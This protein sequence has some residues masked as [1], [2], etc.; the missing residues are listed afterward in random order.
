MSLFPLSTFQQGVTENTNEIFQALDDPF[1]G[2]CFVKIILIWNLIHS[3][4][5]RKNNKSPSSTW[6]NEESDA[7]VVFEDSV[8]PEDICNTIM[9]Y[10]VRTTLQCTEEELTS[11]LNSISK[12]YCKN[13]L[14]TLLSSNEDPDI[15][16]CYNKINS[17][18]KKTEN[19]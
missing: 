7:R 12:E 5:N 4:T 18:I 8:D 17:V 6:E 10:I 16:D 11:T 14:S 13:V 15:K 19:I 2:D 9:E 1:N 3:E